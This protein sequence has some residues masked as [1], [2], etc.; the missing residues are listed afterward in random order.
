[1]D[2]TA[3]LRNFITGNF[4]IEDR[5]T[6][7]DQTSLIETGIID[8]LGIMKVLLFIERTFSFQV[9]EQDV[10]PEYFESIQALAAYLKAHL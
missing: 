4:N 2:A 3:Q 9:P 8:S 1:M 5:D 10:V 7:S 6:F